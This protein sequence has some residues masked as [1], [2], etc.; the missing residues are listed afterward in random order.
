MQA[1]IANER[2]L[3]DIGEISAAGAV[4]LKKLGANVVVFGEMYDDV[5]S[6]EV[7][8]TVTFQDFS[9][10]KLLIKSILMRR[11]LVRD[12]S[13]RRERLVALVDAI[14][15]VTAPTARV[16]GKA[17]RVLQN[18]FIFDL[19]DCKLTDRTLLCHM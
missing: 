17:S 5:E 18:D 12:A 10:K 2:A 6:G 3:Q 13:S 9:G 19:Q 1:V 8:I 11:G 14:A 15:G 4:E 16:S 7:S